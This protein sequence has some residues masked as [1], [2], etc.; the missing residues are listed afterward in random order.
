MYIEN[1]NIYRYRKIVESRE[2]LENVG[3]AEKQLWKMLD[4][5]KILEKVEKCSI[6]KL[7]NGEWKLK[8]GHIR[9]SKIIEKW[10]KS[11]KVLKKASVNIEKLEHRIEINSLII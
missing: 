1:R 8:K 4:K 7:K 6:G 11:Q 5:F 3:K 2:K 9:E 10:R